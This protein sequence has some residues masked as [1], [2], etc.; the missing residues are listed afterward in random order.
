MN[1]KVIKC[2][3]QT[4]RRNHQIVGLPV[5]KVDIFWKLKAITTNEIENT[6]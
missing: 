4:K 5:K 2:I 1:N 3:C 6:I